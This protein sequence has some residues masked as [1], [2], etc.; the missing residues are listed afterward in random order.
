MFTT[1]LLNTKRG[2]NLPKS[3]HKRRNY[4]FNNIPQEY[5]PGRDEA[6][7]NPLQLQLNL[8]KTDNP[9]PNSMKKKSQRKSL[10]TNSG[11]DD[12]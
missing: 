4:C 5:K 2:N 3:F 1:Y 9:P 10:Q 12:R 8:A 6:G 11:S 7:V